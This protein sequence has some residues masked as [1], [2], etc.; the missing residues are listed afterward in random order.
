[1]KDEEISRAINAYMLEAADLKVW[2]MYS[3][4]V[5]LNNGPLSW[6]SA[7]LQRPV[8]V[9]AAL[10]PG[11]E[12]LGSSCLLAALL[13]LL[14]NPTF[15]HCCLQLTCS[16]RCMCM[17]P[18]CVACRSWAAA[19]CWLLCSSCRCCSWAVHAWLKATWLAS[20]CSAADADACRQLVPSVKRQK[21]QNL[22][23][24]PN[25]LDLCYPSRFKV[26]LTRCPDPDQPKATLC[27]R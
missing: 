24:L 18:C 20:N 12:K 14:I 19:A 6:D 4:R 25:C 16:A 26:P 5:T 27:F 1:M 8:H 15:S 10:L 2:A 13:L 21:I 22:P 7:H 3:F 17:Q 11:L 23:Y 9:Y